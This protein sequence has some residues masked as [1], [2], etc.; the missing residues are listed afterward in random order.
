MFASINSVDSIDL[1]YTYPR[2]CTF[3]FFC[4][5]VEK[6][7]SSTSFTT[8]SDRKVIPAL[9]LAL[10]STVLCSFSTPSCGKSA[11]V[12]FSRTRV[13]G[14]MSS[15]PWK[16]RVREF[17]SGIYYS[18][19]PVRELSARYFFSPRTRVRGIV[20]SCTEFSPGDILSRGRSERSPRERMSPENEVKI[21]FSSLWGEKK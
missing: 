2:S 15:Q 21:A 16:V 18:I 8:W 17:G 10:L 1:L 20:D 14:K 6:K 3:L 12:H 13:R 7:F 19:T 11:L 9:I 4:A 5:C